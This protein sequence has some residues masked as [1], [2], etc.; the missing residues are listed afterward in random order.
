MSGALAMVYQRDYDQG[1][2]QLARDIDEMLDMHRQCVREVAS[3]EKKVG[4]KNFARVRRT[5][6]DLMEVAARKFKPMSLAQAYNL[7]TGARP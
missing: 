2:V 4:R 7:A 3:F 1:T 5:M 6:A